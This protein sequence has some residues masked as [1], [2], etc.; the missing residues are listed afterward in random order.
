VSESL[1]VRLGRGDA[2]HDVLA[3]AHIKIEVGEQLLLRQGIGG[4]DVDR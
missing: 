3:V 2:A 1:I 4:V